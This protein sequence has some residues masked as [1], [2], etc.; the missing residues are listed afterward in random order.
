MASLYDPDAEERLFR[1]AHGP[2]M[3]RGARCEECPLRSCRRGPVMGEIRPGSKLAVVGE[4]PGPS[5]VAEG[6]PFVGFSGKVLEEAL[7]LGK[8]IREDVTITNACL[9]QPP[10]VDMQAYVYKLQHRHDRAAKRAKDASEPPPP[11]LV[12]PYDACAPR[13]KRDLDETGAKT[14]LALGGTALGA[15]AK[16]YGVHFAGQG[17][18]AAL[19]TVRVNTISKQH[20][21]PVLLP[22]GTTLMSAFH[23][24]FAA[25]PDSRKWMP[26][27]YA[28]IQKAAKV[29]LRG[30]QINWTEP[31][32]IIAPTA[33]VA[34][35]VLDH[36]RL[37]SMRTRRT[38]TTDIETNSKWPYKAHI[39]CI[40]VGF[41]YED[42]TEQVMVVPFRYKDGSSFWGNEAD[43][44]RVANAFEALFRDAHIAGQNLAFDTWVL[45][46]FGLWPNDDGDPNPKQWEDLMYGQHCSNQSE[47]PKDLGF[48]AS[49]HTEAPRWKEDADAKHIEGAGDYELWVYC[50]KDVL[51]EMRCVPIVFSRTKATGQW[52]AY[53]TVRELAPIARQM[54]ELGLIYD[55]KRRIEFFHLMR[56]EA[57]SK[58]EELRRITGRKDFNPG[59][60]NHVR[61]WLYDDLDLTPML[62]TGGDPWPK[63]KDWDADDEDAEED[64][65]TSE[66]ALLALI[67]GGLDGA[68]Q[69]AIDVLLKWRQAEKI[70]GTYLGLKEVSG[71]SEREARK[72]GREIYQVG[73][74]TLADTSQ[75]QWEDTPWGRLPILHPIWKLHVVVTLRFASSPNM[76]NVPQAV[77]LPCPCGGK[78]RTCLECLCSKKKDC[79]VCKGVESARTQTGWIVVNLREMFIAPPGHKFVGADMEQ[80]ELR[81]YALLSGDKLLLKA[82][83]EG[84]DPHAMNYA[85]MMFGDQGDDRVMREY[86]RLVKLGKKHPEVEF[87]RTAAKRF[88]YLIIYG[89]ELEKLYATMRS[90]RKPNG[91]LAFK[92][93]SYKIVKGWYENWHTTHP[94]TKEWQKACIKHWRHHGY[95]QGLIDEFK[96]YFIGGLDATATPNH[97][98]QTTAAAILNMATKK[99]AKEIP[100]RGWSHGSGTVTQVH[101][102]LGSIVPDARAE[103][104]IGI[105]K[106]H[107]PTSIGGMNFPV[108]EPKAHVRLSEV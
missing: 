12:L 81:I 19:G 93:L 99:I 4:A 39:R 90:E 30:G 3:A 87:A 94:E 40:G 108:D 15:L 77:W 27:V 17:K 51:G 65:S 60:V 11:P 33:D 47:L 53:E 21:A 56:R 61:Q 25:R 71:D 34:V 85:N 8:L 78:S 44:E 50:G 98:I 105:Y 23:P 45:K 29:A 75:I 67:D 107:M 22:D 83:A 58:F 24:A 16:H 54:G 97:T 42:G 7:A 26:V 62:S 102:F 14:V 101:D 5:E 72:K 31:E 20:G 48:I 9:C 63:G 68:V 92:D 35:K 46:R 59:S 55:Q 43:K 38:V 57:S 66:Q 18:K 69:H 89:G 49:R 82:F 73:G 80:I 79:R 100:H 70:R 104:A 103:E 2:A 106:R 91:E 64:P 41:T 6:S 1:E 13:L 76:Q 36:M 28:D 52:K 32:F 84:L 10:G 95:V 88:V 37:A 96:R 86:E 74:L